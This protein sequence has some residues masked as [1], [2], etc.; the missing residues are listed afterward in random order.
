MYS[1]NASSPNSSSSSGKILHDLKSVTED[2]TLFNAIFQLAENFENFQD[3]KKLVLMLSDN[4][5]FFKEELEQNQEPDPIHS[6][7]FTFTAKGGKSRVI[8]NVD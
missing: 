3:F 7:L 8:A 2:T 4:L 5:E 1:G 6:R